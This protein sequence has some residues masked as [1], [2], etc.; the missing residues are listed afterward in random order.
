MHRKKLSRC[1]AGVA[2]LVDS[3]RKQAPRNPSA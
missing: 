1:M 2:L 3:E